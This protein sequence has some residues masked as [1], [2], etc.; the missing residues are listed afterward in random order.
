MGTDAT[1]APP[2]SLPYPP[3]GRGVVP[4]LA[5]AVARLASWRVVLATGTLYAAFAVLLFGTTAAFAIPTVASACGQPAPDVRFTSS[6]GDVHAFLDACGPAGRGSYRALQLADLAYPAV[7]A[8]FL[9]SCLALGL[10][11]LAPHRANLAALAAL[12]LLASAFDYV[13]NACAWL[14][15]AAYPGRGPTDGLL[16]LASA[17]KSGTSWASVAL[18]AGVVLALLVTRARALAGRLAPGGRRRGP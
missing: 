17:A 15:L 13:E 3:E 6:A 11:L 18:L 10:R 14:A 7:F 1:S 2:P 8:L 9:A 5:R 12:P 16:G 4:A